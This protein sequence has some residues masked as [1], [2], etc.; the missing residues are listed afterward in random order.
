MAGASS[1]KKTS[2]QGAWLASEICEG[3]IEALR[4]HRMLPPAS[5]VLVMIPGA[6]S[7]PTPAAGEN[8]VFDEHFYKGFGLP[9]RSFF[10]EWLHFFGL[11]PHHL[12]PNAILQ[13]PTFV[14]LCVGFLGI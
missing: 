11:H 14:I 4:H 6:E 8:I 3:H 1:S 9:A 5:Q 7:A 13:L 10:S 2:S 12:A